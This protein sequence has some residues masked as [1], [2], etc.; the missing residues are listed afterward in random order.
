MFWSKEEGRS[1][2]ER[3]RVR[4]ERRFLEKEFRTWEEI[5]RGN[6]RVGGDFERE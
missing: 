6:R 3:E 1:V 4:T 5:L 2:K